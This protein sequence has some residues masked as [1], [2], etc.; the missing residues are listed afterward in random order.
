MI[1]ILLE[2]ITGTEINRHEIFNGQVTDNNTCITCNVH[3]YQGIGSHVPRYLQYEGEVTNRRIKLSEFNDI[4]NGFWGYWLTNSTGGDIDNIMYQYLLVR[5]SGVESKAIEDGYNVHDACGRYRHVLHVHVFGSI[6]NGEMCESVYTNWIS[7][8][9]QLTEL[10][11]EEC[12]SDENEV[13]S[14][15]NM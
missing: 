10:L 14:Y 11:K 13:C 9:V 8:Q 7:L 15:I 2:Q 1:D 3:M 4:I 5:N 12:I 6:M